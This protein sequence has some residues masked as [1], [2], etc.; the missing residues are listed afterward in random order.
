MA[1]GLLGRK[2]GMTHVY[3]GGQQVASTVIEV[4]PN[5]VVQV[6][7]GEGRDGYDALQLGYG[8]KKAKRVSAG[9]R[10]HYEQAGVQPRRVLREIRGMAAE[11]V[12]PGGEIR[13][14]DIFAEGDLVHV[15]GESKGRGFAGVMKRH[16]FHG[17]KGSHGTHESKRG[18][19]AIGASA[20]PS[21][22]WKG[23]RMAG[24]MG[25]ER[26]MVKN[27]TIVEVIPEQNLVL[28]A[29]AVPGARN[30]IVEVLKA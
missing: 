4:E 30:S 25:G 28:I 18:P 7:S 22:V 5:P 3:R 29:G 1:Q 8:A 15:R 17:H 23:K 27:L 21:R 19:G 26:V 2:I 13:L 20:D 12:E 24:R 11:G 9:L 16:N 14:E 10:G 6:K